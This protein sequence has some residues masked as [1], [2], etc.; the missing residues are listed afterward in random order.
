L[1]AAVDPG[2]LNL[3]DQRL[4]GWLDALTASCEQTSSPSAD[5]SAT[6]GVGSVPNAAPYHALLHE[7]NEVKDAAQRL[8]ELVAQRQGVSLRHVHF[9]F[10]IDPTADL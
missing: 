9:Q 5:A 1:T 4:C 8:L 3:W 6:T 10:G 7:Y 2:P